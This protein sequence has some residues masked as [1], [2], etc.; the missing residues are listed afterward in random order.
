M[1]QSLVCEYRS[2]SLNR[3][4]TNQLIIERSHGS[5]ILVEADIRVELIDVEKDD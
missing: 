4:D 2:H 1:N 3:F 5:T